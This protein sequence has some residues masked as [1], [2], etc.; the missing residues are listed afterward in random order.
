MNNRI[1]V[2]DFAGVFSGTAIAPP[3]SYALRLTAEF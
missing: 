1:N 2:I 3:R